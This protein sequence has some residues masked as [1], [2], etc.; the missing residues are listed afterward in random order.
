MNPRTVAAALGRELRAFRRSVEAYPD[1]AALWARPAGVPNSGGNLAMH[2]AGNLQFFVG[3]TLGGTGYLRDREGEFAAREMPRAEVLARLEAAELAVE[4]SL[5]TLDPARLAQQYPLPMKERTL[6]VET[7][8]LH[9]VTH[10]AYHLGQLDYHRRIVT[11][12]A[13]GVEAVSSH[14]L[15]AIEP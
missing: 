8:L 10:T 7:A 14:E 13:R 2:V 15:P 4:R 9:L 3:A 5:D 6:S 12:D 1:D 11:G